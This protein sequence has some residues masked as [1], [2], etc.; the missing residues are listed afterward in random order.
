MRRYLETFAAVVI[1]IAGTYG[2]V[3]L[4]AAM[5]RLVY[6]VGDPGTYMQATP[7]E[8]AVGFYLP[9]LLT[10]G[11]TAYAAARAAFWLL[12]RSGPRATAVICSTI[13]VLLAIGAIAAGSSEAL[14]LG[15][16]LVSL[17]RVVG[18]VGGVWAAVA[19]M[20]RPPN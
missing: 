18:I 11:V 3:G 5:L 12:H 1:I 10:G 7:F 20:E 9:A 4:A 8:R 14:P 16:L 6:P 13:F 17:I 19:D 2:L 15:L